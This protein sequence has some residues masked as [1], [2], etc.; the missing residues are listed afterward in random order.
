MTV[1]LV[2]ITVF[3]I[4]YMG[5][6]MKSC[7]WDMGRPAA[8]GRDRGGAVPSVVH[9]SALF[10]SQSAS[11]HSSSSFFLVWQGVEEPLHF[12]HG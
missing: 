1:D 8:P 6:C 11:P 5:D 9:S 2:T 10:E 12:L 7:I 3:R 4:T